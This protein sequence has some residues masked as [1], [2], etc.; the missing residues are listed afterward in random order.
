MQRKIRD[1]NT[2]R[3]LRSGEFIG[4]TACI[5]LLTALAIDIMLPAFGELRTY[6]G[7]R[8][9]STATAQIVT[10]FFLGQ[11]GQLLFGPLSDRFGRVAIL[12][13]GFAL[14]ISGSVAAA[15]SPSLSLMLAARFV[16]GMGAA[17]L[18]VGAIA[19]VRDRFAGDKMA[20]TM[21]LVMTIFLF[22]PVIAPLLGSTILSFAPWQAVF[23]T[24][25]LFALV[26]F[27]WSLRLSESLP[28]ER[29]L[30]LDVSTLI[31]STRRVVSSS[32]F[33]RY[34]LISTILFSAFSSYV[35]SSE[36]MI[37]EIYGRPDLFV[38]IFAAVGIT[39]A[40]FTF[41]NAQLVGRFGTLRS[42][43]GLLV[44]Y[45]LVACLLL[46][47]TLTQNGIP[48]IYLFFGLVALLQSLHVAVSSNSGALAL[49]PMGST[50]GMAAAINGTSFFVFGSSM[51][52]FIDSLLV[53][54][55]LPLAVGYMIAGLVSLVLAYSAH[56]RSL[57]SP[58]I[59]DGHPSVV[60]E[61]LTNDAQA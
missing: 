19:G 23:L 5:M 37:G 6:F 35:G 41:L 11:I 45:V 20:R 31:H 49:E 1:M 18:T 22:V 10:F 42:V 50:A 29:R 14:Y 15:L 3:T 12:R 26:I 16:V 44:V 47:L 38:W 17:A 61:S 53:D 30:K 39:M 33:I 57:P 34:T 36:R 4:L 59:L 32:V 7:L 8:Q 46:G 51:G 24:P 54:S 55:V 28:M 27:L 40:I 56:R 48:K 60:T 25:A 21:S 2:T 52:A 43:Q 9:D 13:I 58:P